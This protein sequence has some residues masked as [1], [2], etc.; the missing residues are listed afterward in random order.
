MGRVVTATDQAFRDAAAAKAPKDRSQTE[1]EAAR[2]ERRCR[3]QR[4]RRA[5]ARWGLVR[6]AD[7]DPSMPRKRQRSANWGVLFSPGVAQPPW[8]PLQQHCFP[9]VSPWAPPRH[10]GFP[11]LPSGVFEQLWAP[12]R[13]HSFPHLPSGVFEQALMPPM[14]P[15]PAAGVLACPTPQYASEASHARGSLGLNRS[16]PQLS[17]AVSGSVPTAALAAAVLGW[18][19]PPVVQAGAAVH[20]DEAK[21]GHDGERGQDRGSEPLE[22][23][24]G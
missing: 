24:S 15:Y 11:H 6:S 10:H 13:P 2:L 7:E 14:P 9:L 8:V 5:R 20:R 19:Q 23:E 1:K 12:H 4:S 16:A 18:T 22:R 3:D 21:A 17:T